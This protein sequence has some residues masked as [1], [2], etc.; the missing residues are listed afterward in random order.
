MKKIKIGIAILTSAMLISLGLGAVALAKS[1]LNVN[2]NVNNSDNGFDNGKAKHVQDEII[3]KFKGDEKPFRVIKVPEGKVLEEVGKYKKRSDIEYA[4]PNYIAYAL[5][6]PND[7]HYHYQWHL[8]NPEY[9]GIQME[10]AWD[11]ST[12]DPSVVVAI[13]DTGIAYED[14]GKF[15]QAPDLAK[16][17]F[18]AG[19]DF[20]NDDSHPNDD[21]RH[22]THVAGTVGQ[23]TNNSIGVAGGA[24]DTCLMPVKV[25]DKRGSGTYADVAEGIRWAADNGAKVINLS[26]GGSSADETLKGA[27]QYAYE[28]GATVIAACGNDNAGSCLYPAAYD[29]Y[30]IAVGATQYDE[31]KAP[32]SNYGPSLDLVAPG[33]NTNLDQNNDGYGDGVLQQTFKSSYKLCTFNYYFFQGTSMATPHV[34]G[35]AALLIANGNA[36]TPSEVRAALQE[37]AEDK[38]ISERDD[39]YGWGIID[40]FAALGWTSA[41]DTT[42][43]VISNGKPTGT[44]NANTPVLEVTTDEKATCKGSI[45]VDEAYVDMDFT[46]TADAAGTSHSYQMTTAMADGNHTPYVKCKDEAGNINET[47]YKWTFTVDTIAPAKVT[48]LTV[49]TVSDSQLDLSWDASSATDLDHYSVYRSTTSGFTPSS[50]NLIAKPTTNSYSGTGLAAST[51]YYYRVSA[52]DKAGNEGIASDEA[53][54]TTKEKTSVKCWSGSNEYL[55]RNKDQAKK[56]CKCAQGTYGYNDYTNKRAKVTVYQYVDTGDNEN[57]DVES[58]SSY[59]PVYKVTCTDG[60]VYLTNQDYSYPK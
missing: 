1:S 35:V 17:C 54:G 2:N 59:L 18:V 13:V 37:T 43:P 7:E 38:G 23:S 46:F 33:G 8:D 45:D 36:I 44:I 58:K 4:E 31:T 49:T 6:V 24:F 5:M 16:T 30:V 40:A 22:G 53:S 32:Y 51:T 28:K 60:N 3:I 55:Y 57:W 50:D 21:N 39:T 56:F 52:V 42:P 48:G 25:L 11:V 34:S 26:L 41:P 10:E 19:Y 15:C 47:N 20:V 9:G 12:G 29:N 14:S 27:V